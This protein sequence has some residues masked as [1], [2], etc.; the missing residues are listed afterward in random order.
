MQGGG[1]FSAAMLLV[2][3]AI[4]QDLKVSADQ[5][6]EIKDQVDKLRPPPLPRDGRR[7]PEPDRAKRAAEALEIEKKLIDLLSETQKTRLQQL[8]WQ[9]RGTFALGDKEVADALLLSDEQRER[10]HTLQEKAQRNMWSP[11]GGGGRHPPDQGPR[12]D[13]F[14][15]KDVSEKTLLVLTAEQRS[16][17]KAMLGEPFHGEVRF[18]RP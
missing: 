8:I 9:Q 10:I 13:E 4:Q 2:Q 7:P 16:K 17:W 14:F 5:V 11:N 18:V 3:P 6:K 12:S 15:W 1:G